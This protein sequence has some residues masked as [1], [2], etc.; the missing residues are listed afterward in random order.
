MHCAF[1]SL[2]FSTPP[3]CTVYIKVSYFIFFL[4]RF[5]KSVKH[6]EKFFGTDNRSNT[7]SE[8]SAFRLLANFCLLIN[9]CRH[10][11]IQPITVRD[12]SYV[13]RNEQPHFGW[14]SNLISIPSINLTKGRQWW[15]NGSY[16]RMKLEPWKQ[17]KTNKF[18]KTLFTL[19]FFFRFQ[20]SHQN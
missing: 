3:Y 7:K 6:S 10:I 19:I 13:I 14:G 20:N 4:S 2:S 11:L 8:P 5:L 9:S 1:Y 16:F 12:N 18:F 17:I 15:T